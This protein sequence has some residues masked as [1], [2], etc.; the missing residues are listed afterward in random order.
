MWRRW[1]NGVPQPPPSKTRR[2]RNIQLS[3]TTKYT[4]LSSYRTSSCISLQKRVRNA[5]DSH[6]LTGISHFV[7]NWVA[8]AWSPRRS[9]LRWNRDSKS[10]ERIYT[11]HGFEVSNSVASKS[12]GWVEYAQASSHLRILYVEISNSGIPRT[13]PTCVYTTWSIHMTR[14]DVSNVSTMMD[15][16]GRIN[17]HGILQAMTSV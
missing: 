7:K 11:L 13:C 4:S 15:L 17:I 2:Q 5:S 16:Y 3:D 9:R 10:M 8:R 6:V 14:K 1:Q 12:G